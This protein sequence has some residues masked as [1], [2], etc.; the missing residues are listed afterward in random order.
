MKPSARAAQDRSEQWRDYM[1]DVDERL[2]G[3]GPVR[4]TST[5]TEQAARA[6][7]RK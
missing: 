1:P 5:A 3:A 7:G 6:P 4:S 2:R